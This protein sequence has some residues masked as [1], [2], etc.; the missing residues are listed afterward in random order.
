MGSYARVLLRRAVWTISV[1]S[2]VFPHHAPPAWAVRVLDPLVE[3]HSSPTNSTPLENLLAHDQ[4]AEQGLFQS[5]EAGLHDVLDEGH[6]ADEDPITE[7]RLLQNL[8]PASPRIFRNRIFL[9]PPA[10]TYIFWFETRTFQTGA[11]ATKRFLQNLPRAILSLLSLLRNEVCPP[12]ARDSGLL[13]LDA[14]E[15]C[16]LCCNAI[17]CGEQLVRCAGRDSGAATGGDLAGA[18]V[19]LRGIFDV[20]GFVVTVDEVIGEVIQRCVCR[21][22]YIYMRLYTCVSYTKM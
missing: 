4:R 19:Q 12:A 7:A 3:D 5:A 13:P 16:L 2:A 17:L 20:G 22:S 21:R 14:E 6:Q 15:T 8:P 9:P 10:Q 1:L 11:T 18:E